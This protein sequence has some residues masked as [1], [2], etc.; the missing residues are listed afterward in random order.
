VEQE[1]RIVMNKGFKHIRAHDRKE[2]QQLKISLEEMQKNSQASK[3]LEDRQGELVKQLQVKVSLT[4]NTIVDISAFRFQALEIHEKLG[5]THQ[6]FFT[7]IEGIQNHYR[8]TE[9]S[10]NNICIKVKED[11]IARFTFQEA[12]LATTKEEVERVIR[13]SL[14]EQT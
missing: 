3:E 14:L 13:F 1:V 8:S 9:H 5:S 10:L 7:K 12:I 4:E 2:I 11:T 6:R